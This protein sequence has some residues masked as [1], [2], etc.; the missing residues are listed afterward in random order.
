[1]EN[2]GTETKNSEE[3]NEETYDEQ[4]HLAQTST[5]TSTS[6]PHTSHFIKRGRGRPPKENKCTETKNS[7]EMNE[8]TCEK[9]LHLAQTST[10]KPHYIPFCKKR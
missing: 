9:Q 7:Q 8:E 3:R 10:S 1:M 5:S 2:N 6:K 4:L